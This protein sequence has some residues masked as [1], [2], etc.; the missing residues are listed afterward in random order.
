M[1]AL[2]ALGVLQGAPGVLLKSSHEDSQWWS[3]SGREVPRALGS[4]P[5]RIRVYRLHA[6]KVT[7]T[8]WGA[9]S[10]VC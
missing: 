9:G 8:K 4:V 2:S 3:V 10:S 1:L 6:L 5:R 7:N